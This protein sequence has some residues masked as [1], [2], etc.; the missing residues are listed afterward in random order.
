MPNLD[1]V[2]DVQK[3]CGE[4]PTRIPEADIVWRL[5]GGRCV[6]IVGIHQGPYCMDQCVEDIETHERFDIA[7]LT[8]WWATKDDMVTEVPAMEVLARAARGIDY[9]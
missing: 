2:L 9:V 4:K 6:S 7:W 5:P 8:F 1:R 3:C